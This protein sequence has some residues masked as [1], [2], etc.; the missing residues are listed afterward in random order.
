[1]VSGRKLDTSDGTK[2]CPK[3]HQT[4]PFSA[5]AID[6]NNFHGIATYCRE[7]Q[8]AKH[9]EWR[10][11]AGNKQKLAIDQKK[12]RDA[13]PRLAKDFKLRKT[14]G[15]P[16][17]WYDETLAAQGGVCAACGTDKP[18]GRGDFHV[19]HC[20]D[21]GHVRGL[22]CA[23]CNV[24]IG[25]LHHSVARMEAAIRYLNRTSLRTPTEIQSA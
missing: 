9:A 1:M 14:Y 21:H 15:V 11:R 4:K 23:D 6:K 2:E 16:L 18:G 22:L 20:H 24:G 8:S 12:W 25:Y 19:D 3:C 13:N 10:E 7:C 17:G 5:Y